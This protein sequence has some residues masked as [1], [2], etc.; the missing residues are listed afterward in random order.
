MPLFRRKKKDHLPENL[1]FSFSDQPRRSAKVMS[2]NKLKAKLNSL[3]R[4]IRSDSLSL[5]S[6][7]SVNGNGFF[8]ADHDDISETDFLRGE[9]ALP[10]DLQQY[11][12]HAVAV[13]S[14]MAPVLSSNPMSNASPCAGFFIPE[15]G[16]MTSTPVVTVD[17]DRDLAHLDNKNRIDGTEKPEELSPALSPLKNKNQVSNKTSKSL[18]SDDGT[19]V[20]YFEGGDTD[21]E[22]LA[23]DANHLSVS[24]LLDTPDK[25]APELGEFIAKLEDS[26]T[27]SLNSRSDLILSSPEYSTAKKKEMFNK[28]VEDMSEVRDSRELFA[29]IIENN[30]GQ[31]HSKLI[32][33]DDEENPVEATVEKSG[34][35]SIRGEGNVEADRVEWK[36]LKRFAKKKDNKV[37]FKKK[38]ND[39]DG[40]SSG[41]DSLF[42]GLCD[43]I[44]TKDSSSPTFD[45]KLDSPND[46]ENHFE[47]S[48][49][50]FN[51]RGIDVDV[52]LPA[53]MP[54]GQ[55]RRPLPNVP[56]NNNSLALGRQRRR[57]RPLSNIFSRIF[58]KNTDKS[59]DHRANKSAIGLPLASVST[60]TM[61]IG[62]SCTLPSKRHSIADI[63]HRPDE[64]SPS[65]PRPSEFTAGKIRPMS[66]AVSQLLAGSGAP[67]F[68]AKNKH[69][70][71]IIV[72]DSVYDI[73]ANYENMD[74]LHTSPSKTIRSSREHVATPKKINKNF[75]RAKILKKLQ[76]SPTISIKD[77]VDSPPKI[78]AMAAI[79]QHQT[80]DFEALPVQ[81][82]DSV[83]KMRNRN[84][85][86]ENNESNKNKNENDG[87]NSEFSEVPYRDKPIIG[88]FSKRHSLAVPDQDKGIIS[89]SR[90]ALFMQAGK[91]RRRPFS[92][93]YSEVNFSESEPVRLIRY[94]PSVDESDHDLPN[95][96]KSLS[97][98]I[99]ADN[100]IVPSDES[101]EKAVAGFT[102]EG[103]IN[104]RHK[105]VGRAFTSSTIQLETSPMPCSSVELPFTSANNSAISDNSDVFLQDQQQS[106]NLGVSFQLLNLDHESSLALPLL[107]APAK[108]PRGLPSVS[109]H[110]FGWFDEKGEAIQ[111]DLRA[112][113]APLA[114][115]PQR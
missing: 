33:D 80:E 44:S 3:E 29:N 9:H 28:L 84:R 6:P 104:S 98:V 51:E 74:G 83:V 42:P 75:S 68:T 111:P 14:N 63:Q 115:S 19:T 1:L 77:V 50:G 10:S 18:L 32:D 37:L 55:L 64:K 56:Q 36:S 45:G 22:K 31:E 88:S 87:N 8:E 82:S 53:T 97:P 25:R 11:N 101:K 86:H 57:S 54:R 109:I 100:Y 66:M 58:N 12:G 73:V 70:S 103:Q 61:P 96:A 60:S 67:V 13:Q 113:Q 48:P 95:E 99:N 91:H 7:N 4:T 110:E 38:L 52:S 5:D 17:K 90:S 24:S 106:P 16:I 79:K 85:L 102:D 47:L 34:S 108:P 107:R 2:P 59:K 30:T 35:R 89:S 20:I 114:V 27:S 81:V 94:H 65:L 93:Y 69:H 46:K 92:A 39:T 43:P 112:F 40:G 21:L 71:T 78:D 62:S 41:A 72:S 105:H 26:L 76:N 15:E 49:M 23:P